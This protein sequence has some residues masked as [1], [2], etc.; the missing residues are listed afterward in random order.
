MGPWGAVLGMDSLTP[1]AS[2]SLAFTV[3]IITSVIAQLICVIKRCG[4]NWFYN[5]NSSDLSS[6]VRPRG[7]LPAL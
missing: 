7:S 4:G 6:T 1:S 3:L 5:N 2:P